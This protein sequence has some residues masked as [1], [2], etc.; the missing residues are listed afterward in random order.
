MTLLGFIIMLGSSDLWS[1]DRAKFQE[2]IATRALSQ[3]AFR[4]MSAQTI[5]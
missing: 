2:N 5:S 1:M 4:L 3:G